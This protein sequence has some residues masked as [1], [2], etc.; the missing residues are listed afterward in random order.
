MDFLVSVCD[1]LAAGSTAGWWPCVEQTSG[2]VDPIRMSLGGPAF[3]IIPGG[4]TV[5]V[6]LIDVAGNES[7]TVAVAVQRWYCGL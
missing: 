3:F 5:Y 1:E 6:S 7:N 4:I 2:T